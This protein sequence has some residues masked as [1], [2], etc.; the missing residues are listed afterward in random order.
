MSERFWI[1]LVVAIVILLV[2]LMLRRKL[3][4]LALK[5]MGMEAEVQTHNADSGAGPKAEGA[6]QPS[7]NIRDFSQ[8]GSGNVLNIS[9][10]DVNVERIKQ[11][12]IDQ[13]INVHSEKPEQK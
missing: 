11:K 1:I 10:D 6:K 12:G 3:K 2:V 7:V 8:D 13:K 4:S 5:G 9:R